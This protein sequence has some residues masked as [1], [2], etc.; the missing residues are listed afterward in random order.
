[1]CTERLWWRLCNCT[2][3]VV[4]LCVW[5]RLRYLRIS[6]PDYVYL[7]CSTYRYPSTSARSLCHF[8][9]TIIIYL[10]TYLCTYCT[11]WRVLVS[12]IPAMLGLPTTNHHASLCICYSQ[13][14]L[15][16]VVD[17]VNVFCWLRD[18]SRLFLQQHVT[19]T[20]ESPCDHFILTQLKLKL[21]LSPPVAWLPKYVLGILRNP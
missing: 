4:W 20:P 15:N 3:L 2:P 1:M 7:T 6:Q 18:R 13:S 10:Y 16:S 11:C 12:F 14:R 5:G 21:W 9:H 19:R 8:T 17:N